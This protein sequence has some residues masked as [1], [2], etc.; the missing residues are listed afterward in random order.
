MTKGMHEEAGRAVK[1]L[2]LIMVERYK[3]VTDVTMADAER[4]L[5]T[6]SK[7]RLC[8]RDP[9][10]L[11]EIFMENCGAGEKRKGAGGG[12][13]DLETG[14]G[15]NLMMGTRELSLAWLLGVVKHDA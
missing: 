14:G 15:S 5:D 13:E 11:L 3:V 8:R 6:A 2:G 4:V 12:G 9:E 10:L 7:T 1:K